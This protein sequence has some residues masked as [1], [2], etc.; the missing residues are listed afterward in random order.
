M[1]VPTPGEV[2]PARRGRRGLPDS[3]SSRAKP[4]DRLPAYNGTRPPMT[5]ALRLLV[6]L[7][8]PALANAA[9]KTYIALGDSVASGFQ[10][11]DYSRGSGDKGYVRQV[12]DWLGTQQGGVRPVLINLGVPGE[13]SASF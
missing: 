5:R 2:A 8:A 11:N 13:T 1:I 6:L 7:L 10:P 3:P 4:R 12:A 9:T